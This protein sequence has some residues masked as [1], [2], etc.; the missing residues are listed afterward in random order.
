MRGSVYGVQCMRGSVYE[1]F[2]VYGAVYIVQC[3]RFSV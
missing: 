2:S 3:I 1:G